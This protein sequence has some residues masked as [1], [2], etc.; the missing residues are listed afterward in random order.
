MKKPCHTSDS[1]NA[2][3]SKLLALTRNTG[4]SPKGICKFVAL[5]FHC[6]PTHRPAKSLEVVDQNSN[7][8]RGGI[9]HKQFTQCL[10]A[11]L[12]AFWQ[13]FNPQQIDFSCVL[14]IFSA[15]RANCGLY[16]FDGFD[17]AFQ[18]EGSWH[19]RIQFHQKIRQN[20]C[21]AMRQICKSQFVPNR[22]LIPIFQP[23]SKV[24]LSKM[25]PEHLECQ[26]SLSSS[27]KDKQLEVIP[28]HIPFAIA[29]QEQQ[30]DK[31]P[32]SIVHGKCNRGFMFFYGLHKNGMKSR[33][34]K[35]NTQISFP[36]VEIATFFGRAILNCRFY[37]MPTAT[38]VA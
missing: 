37:S 16:C 23:N 10:L 5:R 3:R 24:A 13:V 20:K 28:S 36:F 1:A 9:Q 19:K 18:R 22:L 8:R 7:I 34:I 15:V 27:K 31:F 4:N 6:S 12:L 17:F 11:R 25:I 26:H 32:N 30:K 29:N 21:P 38:Y 2:N 35:F 14:Q 33:E